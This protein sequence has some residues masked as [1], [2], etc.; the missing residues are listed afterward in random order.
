MM[1]TRPIPETTWGN[2][3]PPYDWWDFFKGRLQQEKGMDDIRQLLPRSSC[4]DPA[5]HL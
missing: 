4:P 2:L 3:W 1:E 5:E